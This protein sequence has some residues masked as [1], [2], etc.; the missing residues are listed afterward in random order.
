MWKGSSGAK[1]LIQ[2]IYLHFLEVFGAW[3]TGK[4]RMSWCISVP[5]LSEALNTFTFYNKEELRVGRPVIPQV[6]VSSASQ[7]EE[8]GDIIVKEKNITHSPQCNLIF[9][10]F[11]LKVNIRM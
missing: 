11:F 4:Y 2:F 5:I 6:F 3:S 10:L 8:E 9:N 1:V 7:K